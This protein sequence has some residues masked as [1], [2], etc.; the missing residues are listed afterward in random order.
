MLES[1]SLT[2]SVGLIVVP[3]LRED[4]PPMITTLHDLGLPP[5]GLTVLGR[6]DLATAQA[7]AAAGDA[8]PHLGP[9]D[10]HRAA[11]LLVPAHDHEVLGAALGTAFGLL[12]GIV[13]LALP[14][15]APVLMVGSAAV[16][17]SLEAAAGVVGT[18][19]GATVGALLDRAIT[20]KHETMF[21]RVLDDDRWIVVVRGHTSELEAA[22]DALARFQ[23]EHCDLV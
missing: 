14:G 3:R 20:Q 10:A 17:A 2:R 11:A 23:P 4:L 5:G 21:Q 1:H 9:H 13:A 16:V 8:P 15:A 7:L 22:R 6:T 18:G 12:G 19:I